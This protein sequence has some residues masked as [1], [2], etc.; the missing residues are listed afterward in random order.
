MMQNKDRWVSL[1]MAANGVLFMSTYL[2]LGVYNRLSADDFHYMHMTREL[3]VWDAM[4]FYYQNWNP[5]WSS[6]LLLNTVLGHYVE[7]VSLAF[8]HFLTMFLGCAA[9]VVLLWS[10]VRRLGLRITGSEFAVMPMYMMA[11]LFH[12]SIGTGDTWFWLSSM[13]M[14]LWGLM[15]VVLGFGLLLRERLSALH[16]FLVFTLFLFAGGAAE[17]VAVATLTVLFY[18]GLT[19]RAGQG[20]AFH[21]ATLACLAGFCIDAMGSG[22]QVRMEHLPH[23]AVSE[24]LWEGMKN[25]GRFIFRHVPLMLPALIAFLLP[26]AWVGRRSEHLQATDLRSLYVPSRH[27][28]VIA[29][30]IALGIS[31]M[32][33][34]LMSGM[35]PERAWLPVSAMVL[36]IGVLVAVRSGRW[37]FDRAS[38]RFFHMVIL[39]Q[40]LLLSFQFREMVVNVGK[41]KVY[42][43]AVDDRMATIAKAVAEGADELILRPL[44]DA[45]WLHSAEITSDTSHHLNQHLSLHF[46]G[47]IRLS[48]SQ[49]VPSPSE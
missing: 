36:A 2:A 26:L 11:A 27:A 39:S 22:I 30:L 41:A 35:G 20:R 5:R 38:G 7:G 19:G 10:L 15:A 23:T 43:L 32:M 9:L 28:F 49:Q 31:F 3:G 21:I 6:T 24:R 16:Y 47:S 42:A 25:Y 18:L 4:V 13:S 37:L 46:G 40:V 44:P 33:G 14:Y 29:D 8:F 17:T 45:G 48:T 12:V 34:L 1:L